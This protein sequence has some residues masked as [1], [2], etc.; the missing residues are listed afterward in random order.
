MSRV[1]TSFA[2]IALMIST[3]L[4]HAQTPAP[5]NSDIPT[6]LQPW[7]GW[8]LHDVPNINCPYSIGQRQCEWPGDLSVKVSE[9]GAT[10]VLQ[11][12]VDRDLKVRL[13]GNPELWPQSVRTDT[14]PT[15]V[16]SDATGLPYAQLTRGTHTI[17]GEFEWTEAPEIIPIPPLAGRIRLQI[18]NKAIPFPRVT[19]GNLYLGDASSEEGEAD[20]LRVSVYRRFED[21]VPMRVTTRLKLSVSGKAREVDLG[22]IQLPG[23]VP[24]GVVSALPTRA[25]KD[26]PVKVYV[27]PGT[28][29]VD[30]SSV[31]TA[32][33]TEIKV[34][35]TPTP[36]YEP[37][38]VWVWRPD[39]TVRSVQKTGLA[40]VD[41]ERTTLPEDWHGDSTYWAKQGEVWTF[42]ETRRGLPERPPNLININRELWLDLDGTGY[43]VRDTVTGQMNQGWRLN[44]SAGGELGRASQNGQDLFITEDPATK[45]SGI[46]IRER[47]LNVG[48]ELRLP[49]NRE[50]IRIVGWEHDV[51]SLSATLNLPPGW[52]LLGGDGVDNMP[53]TWIDSWTLWDFFFVLM[54]ALAIGKL[55]GWGW[56]PVTVIALCLAHGHGD[57]PKW[58]WIQLI[59][60]L[61]LIR[62]VPQGIWRKIFV[63][64]RWIAVGVL[65]VI[66]APYAQQQVR[67]AMHPQVGDSNITFQAEQFPLTN[68]DIAP[69]AP[70][71]KQEE[72][73]EELAAAGEGFADFEEDGRMET[74][75]SLLASRSMSKRPAKLRKKGG[76]MDK[77][78]S[79]Y[80]MQQIAPDSVVQTGPGL[81]TWSWTRWNLNW[82]GPV[83]KDHQIKLYLI[84]PHINMIITFLRVA[85]LL[86]LA[87]L[88]LAPMEMYWSK[89]K[90]SGGIWTKVFGQA[91]AF[92]LC[93]G[94]VSH[95]DAQPQPQQ[96]IQ[97][98]I[99]GIQNLEGISAPDEDVLDSLKRRLV[100]KT[101]CETCVIASR[102]DF[103]VNGRTWSMTAEL[104]V[105]KL[106]SW[107]LPGTADAIALQSVQVD[108]VQTTQIRRTPQGLTRVRL[109]PGR[110]I[111]T[112]R[113]QLASRNVITVQMDSS[114]PPK[115]VT[116]DS[117][118]WTVD[119][120]SPKG[121]PD[122]SL[123]LTRKSKENVAEQELVNE[124]PPYY[125]VERAFLLGLPWQITTV[126]RREDAGR[127]QLVKIPLLPGEKVI[128]AETRVEENQALVNFD[129]GVEQVTITSEIPIA[130]SL[131]LKA[132]EGQPWNETWSIDCS[133]IWRCAFSGVPAI[134]DVQGGALRPTYKPWPGEELTIEVAKP[135]GA[136]G[137]ATTIESVNYTMTPGKR[138]MEAQL[139]M[140]VRASQGSRQDV[141]LPAGAELQK[142]TIDNVEKSIRPTDGVVSLPVEP[143]TQTYVLTWQQAWERDLIEQLPQIDIGGPAVNTELQIRL[144]EERWLVWTQ[145]P[146]WGP[147]ILFWSHLGF[148]LLLGLILGL[149]K[150]VPIRWWEWML[151]MIG[152]SQLPV[153]VVIPVVLW[154][155]FLSWRKRTPP[156]H[157]AAFSVAQLAAVFLTML[158]LGALYAAV[159]TNLLIDIDMQVEGARSTNSV[160]RWYVDQTAGPL[161]QASI[162]SL[163]I[164]VWRTTMLLWAF[165]LVWRLLG[166][167]KW[168]WDCFSDGGFWKKPPPRPK[169]KTPPNSGVTRQQR[170]QVQTQPVEKVH[171]GGDTTL[172][173]PS[174]TTKVTSSVAKPVAKPATKPAEQPAEK[175]DKPKLPKLQTGKVPKPKP[176]EETKAEEEESED[177]KQKPG[178]RSHQTEPGTPRPEREETQ[179]GVPQVD[180]TPTRQPEETPMLFP[181][182]EEE[183]QSEA[184]DDSDDSES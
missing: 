183:E 124:L 165:W 163:P 120:I 111:V 154:F 105:E 102:A 55:F 47:Q 128:S 45:L 159:H 147:A 175:Q 153:L 40:G 144:G 13:P 126:V 107:A 70:M 100:E 34:P 17:R 2:F 63:A 152:M 11:V 164:W 167:V 162:I 118:D 104:H 15:T 18:G 141:K 95:A 97:Q 174:A 136:P 43:T 79:G 28:H 56:V 96:Q 89:P 58:I 67:E 84:P 32:S 88:L 42:Q 115:L 25:P 169:P 30:I 178:R 112:A 86:L 151:L 72:P 7:V 68:S 135:T 149:I 142:V 46:E 150:N 155:V 168:G 166:W 36:A 82:S 31:I 85:L 132:S 59:A 114:N 87:F 22:A 35:K 91:A 116:F 161:P 146:K 44:H 172:E 5:T 23:S 122:A 38:E 173:E 12:Y 125:F 158:A 139:T 181:P 123:Q 76:K 80:Q 171:E 145:G 74:E 53:G 129:R 6:A 66:L 62:V 4:V 3:S 14:A 71:A 37:D 131:T 81:P 83:R 57:A 98:Q 33:V 137:Q 103:R 121:I 78:W 61:A 143:R 101:T 108:G 134:Q 65:A 170:E 60:S 94:V 109:T 90:K 130:E 140:T 75:K 9:D 64:Y 77:D 27:R 1:L 54:V 73:M 21:G 26:G 48:A 176:A 50:S 99:D 138:L 92:V 29:F 106:S 179:I 69:A 133:R 177:G 8:V 49:D 160:L 51:Q 182:P 41:P 52:T 156:E 93:L 24:V 119:G 110:H 184:Q 19:D 113:G 127:P 157:W 16:V 180:R 10:F 148:L 39:E 117:D 20:S